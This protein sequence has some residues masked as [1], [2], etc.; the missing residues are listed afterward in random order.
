M[1]I[2]REREDNPFLRR[3]KLV[4]RKSP[5]E[6]LVKKIQDSPSNTDDINQKTSMERVTEKDVEGKPRGRV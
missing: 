4:G 1:Q 6:R 5:S 3:E 2:L